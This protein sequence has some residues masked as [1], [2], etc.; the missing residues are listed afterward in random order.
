V[1]QPN[2]G[3]IADNFK[4]IA[5]FHGDPPIGAFIIKNSISRKDKFSLSP[6]QEWCERQDLNMGTPPCEGVSA[7][8]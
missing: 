2:Q 3:S 1:V 6:Q 4:N 5:V 8:I 7:Q